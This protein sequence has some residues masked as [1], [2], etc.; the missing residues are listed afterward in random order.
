M[1]AAI[2]A[3]LEQKLFRLQEDGDRKSNDPGRVFEFSI[4]DILG[5]R[6]CARDRLGGAEHPCRALADGGGATLDY[7]RKYRRSL[8]QQVCR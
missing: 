8:V 7:L 2:N 4:V 3:G 1:V 5:S 6:L